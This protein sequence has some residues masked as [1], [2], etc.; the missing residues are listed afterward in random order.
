MLSVWNSVRSGRLRENCKLR[1]KQV[2]ITCL[3]DETTVGTT[4]R[5]DKK[6]TAPSTSALIICL[7]AHELTGL[8][9]DKTS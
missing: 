9:R 6:G 7:E 5:Q 1:K 3:S 2:L 8:E 4:G